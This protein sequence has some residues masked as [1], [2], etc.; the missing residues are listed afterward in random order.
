MKLQLP[1]LFELLPT[2][3]ALLWL[4]DEDMFGQVLLIVEESSTSGTRIRLSDVPLHVVC[5]MFFLLE[6]L[7]TDLTLK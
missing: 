6:T 1:F 2:H 7:L 3:L 5:K 4:V